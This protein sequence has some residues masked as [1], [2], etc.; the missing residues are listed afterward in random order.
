MIKEEL[1]LETYQ[2]PVGLATPTSKPELHQAR[3]KKI[4]GTRGVPGSAIY[5]LHTA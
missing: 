4:R 3:I 5:D 1:C 2:E